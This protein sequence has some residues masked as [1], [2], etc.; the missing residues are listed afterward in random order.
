MCRLKKN[1]DF[2]SQLT[3][4]PHFESMRQELAQEEI[5]TKSK[6]L[7]FDIE[8]VFIRKVNIL[9]WEELTMLQNTPQ[10]ELQYKYILIQSDLQN[11]KNAKKNS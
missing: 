8:S 9:D 4:I 5:Y 7:C 2:V 6:T 1:N 3:S 10:N 11:Y